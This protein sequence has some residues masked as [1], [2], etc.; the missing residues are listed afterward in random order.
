[1]NDILILLPPGTI[2]TGYVGDKGSYRPFTTTAGTARTDIEAVCAA[3]AA[4]HRDLHASIP[5]YVRSPETPASYWFYDHDDAP[6]AEIAEFPGLTLYIDTVRTN[7]TQTDIRT[8]P[9]TVNRIAY[10][11]PD[12]ASWD[13]NPDTLIKAADHFRKLSNFL[14]HIA[15]VARV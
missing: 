4:N 6:K 15:W 5:Q 10:E 8:D 9:W 13:A 2:I 14:G 3:H 1:M 12:F 11:S 7:G